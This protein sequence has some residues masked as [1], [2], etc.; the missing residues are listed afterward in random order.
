MGSCSM[1]QKNAFKMSLTQSSFLEA[2]LENCATLLSSDGW[3]TADRDHLINML[4]GNCRA[5]VFDGS[6]GP[7]SLLAATRRMLS[8][9]PSLCG[10]AWSALGGWPLSKWSPTHA[11]R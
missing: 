5:I 2:A 10:S 8:L 3:D 4:Y 9:W 6:M 7:L 11:A 1:I